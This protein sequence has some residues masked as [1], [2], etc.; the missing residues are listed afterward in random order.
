MAAFSRQ[1]IAKFIRGISVRQIRLGCGWCCSPIWSAISSITRS[2][3][4]RWMLWPPASITTPRFWQ[5]LRSRSCF[6]PRRWSTPASDLGAVPAPAISLE[7]D[8]AAPARARPQHSRAHHHPHCRRAAR[9]NPVRT[10]KALSAG[11]FRV[12][13][14]V[15]VQ[16]VA[17]VRCHDHCLGPWLHRTL[18]LAAD[19][20]V[21]RTRGAVS[22]CSSG[23]GSD[24]G[25]AGSLSGR[26]KRRR[27]R[28]REWRAENLS[29]RQV[30]TPAEQAVLEQ[31][32]GVFPDRISRPARP[33]LAGEG[34]ARVERAPRR[35][36]QSVLRQRQDGSRAEGPQRARGQPAQ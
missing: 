13:D 12:L 27:Q 6:T 30:G 17:D 20:G 36:D 18:L 29:P 7:G 2:A 28:Q 8:R 10:R 16:N 31:H 33:C 22:A 1:Q 23:A 26:A 9:P 5:F 11:A 24:A 19:E 14:R 21:L 3:I 34:R 15:A 32:R 4:S 35:H 25:H